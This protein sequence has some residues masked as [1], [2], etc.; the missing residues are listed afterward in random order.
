MSLLFITTS[1]F[2]LYTENVFV[3]WH[4]SQSNQSPYLWEIVLAEDNFLTILVIV[5]DKKNI[6][7]VQENSEET[8]LNNTFRKNHWRNE[9]KQCIQGKQSL[10]K[11]SLFYSGLQ[12]KIT[13]SLIK[14]LSE[15][16]L[17]KTIVQLR[18][19]YMAKSGTNKIP[20]QL[21]L[22]VDM[23]GHYPKILERLY[24]WNCKRVII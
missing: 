18:E 10:D 7:N 14:Q 15:T 16:T 5:K 11:F 12:N 13:K 3:T 20:W 19:W 4:V 6:K 21:K 23:S 22:N 1:S 8:R 17:I 24:A 2:K 9:I